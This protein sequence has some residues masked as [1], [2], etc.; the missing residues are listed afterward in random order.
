MKIR[1]DD[2]WVLL[3][4]DRCAVLKFISDRCASGSS[5]DVHL[6]IDHTD[7]VVTVDGNP[8]TLSSPL[9]ILWVTF[10]PKFDF[11]GHFNEIQVLK[12]S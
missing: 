1:S 10:D 12:L 8:L 9:K 11:S 2:Q 6:G 7:Q 5:S 3:N 4:A